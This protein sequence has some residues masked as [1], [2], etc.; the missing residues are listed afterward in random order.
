M[1]DIGAAGRRVL[2]NKLPPPGPIAATLACAGFRASSS[3][4]SK[5]RF[6]IPGGQAVSGTAPYHVVSI[7]LS[8]CELQYRI[9]GTEPCRRVIKPDK[10]AGAGVLVLHAAP[11]VGGTVISANSYAAPQRAGS[12]YV[13]ARQLI[14]GKDC[15]E[16]LKRPGKA[17]EF[18]PRYAA[19]HFSKGQILDRRGLRGQARTAFQAASQAD[20]NYLPPLIECTTMAAEESDPARA[21]E[22]AARVIGLAPGCSPEIYQDYAGAADRFELCTQYAPRDSSDFDEVRTQAA[23][24]RKLAK[25]AEDW[26]KP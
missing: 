17:N 6:F 3:A 24:M 11:G 7:S 25:M 20:P 18:Y 5:G 26:R 19:S 16:A 22:L 8:G 13:R 21:S 23:S 9:P 10:Q 4:G 2:E 1:M 12:E 14:G 15:G